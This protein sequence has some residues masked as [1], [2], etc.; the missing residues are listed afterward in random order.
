MRKSSSAGYRIWKGATIKSLVPA[1]TR[2]CLEKWRAILKDFGAG[3]TEGKA[4]PQVG[5]IEGI[6]AAA[7]ITALV[8]LP[9]L[10]IIVRGVFQSGIPA[11]SEYLYHLVIWV[12]FLGGMITSRQDKHLS[13][14]LAAHFSRGSRR[15]FILSIG[16]LLSSTVL[17]AL[18]LSALSFI[19]MAFDT[20]VKIGIFP[21]RLALI[22]M[23]VGYLFMALR[24]VTREGIQGRMRWI[25]WAGFP[26]GLLMGLPPLTNLLFSLNV[27]YPLWIDGMLDGWYAFFAVCT[28]P[29]ILLLI[30]AAFLGIPLFVAISGIAYLLFA[31]QFGAMEVIPNEAYTM[32]TSPSIPALPL[33]TLAGYILSESNAGKRLVRLFQAWFGWMPGGLVTASVLVCTFFTTFTGASG[34]TILALGALLA[35]I[36]KEHGVG[37]EFSEGML[38]ASGSIGLLFPPSLPIILYGVVA[39]ISIKDLFLGG[40][41]PGFIMVAAL[42]VMGVIHAVRKKVHLVPFNIKEA[43]QATLGALWEILLPLIIILGYFL[44]ITTIV[45]TGSIAVLYALVVEVFI[46][47]DIRVKDIPG[48]FLKSIPIIGGVLII[49]AAARGLSFFIVDAR[50]PMRLTE[51]VAEHIQSK[52]VFLILLNLALLITGCFMDIFSA[53]MVVVP[54]I[55]PLA[56]LFD[57]HPV[58]LGIIF[59]ANLELGYLTPP[60]GLNLFLAS[61]RFEKTLP[62]VYHRVIPFFLVL[63]VMVLLIT[64]VPMFSLMLVP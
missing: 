51:W 40:I 26:L 23:P 46:H 24:S 61:Y 44:G 58:H 57:I 22:I 36:L 35:Y 7:G 56:G 25:G 55:I 16:S 31:R 63:L 49:L 37:E 14:S 9:F 21:V 17:T 11:Q 62:Q 3:I 27:P 28:V 19:L 4:K 5:K 64:Y 60:V 59:L 32:L 42:A 45:E 20:G 53:I 6:F 50:V 39:G 47:R 52:Y 10:E 38:T 15:S 2:N 54:L 48:V 1:W 30:A 34:V 18:F 12:T 33:F 8:I 41:I 13:I 29:G 43:G